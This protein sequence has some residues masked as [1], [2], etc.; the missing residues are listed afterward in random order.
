MWLASLLLFVPLSTISALGPDTD[1]ARASQTPFARNPE[2]KYYA[3]PFV[4]NVN[5]GY[6]SHGN[7]QA[8][9]DFKPIISFQL[10]SNYDFILR[11]IAPLVDHQP[12]TSHSSHDITG[13]GDLNPTFFISPTRYLTT[14]WGAGPT[15]FIP[16]ATNQAI[17]SG[18]CSVGPELAIFT[19]PDQ[20]VLGILTNN[21][22]SVA[23]D[24]SRQAVDQFSLQYFISYNFPKGWYLTSEPTISANWKAARGQVW[25]VPVGI[26]GGKAFHFPNGGIIL[27]LQSYYN[28]IRPSQLGPNWTLQAKIEFD[29]VDRKV[30]SI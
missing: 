17:G 2:T 19:M 21:V 12:N 18:K 23:G 22:W 3:F 25:T 28:I 15:F 5:F 9:L 8:I 14:I 30:I 1:I 7:T 29:L 24:P 13:W 27:S 20:W 10:S 11:T 6:G 26:G 16:T 4:N